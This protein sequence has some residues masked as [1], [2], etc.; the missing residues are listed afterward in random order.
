MLCMRIPMLHYAT[1]HAVA[2]NIAPSRALRLWDRGTKTSSP[3]HVCIQPSTETCGGEGSLIFLL[4]VFY[5][6]FSILDQFF[7]SNKKKSNFRFSK[8]FSFKARSSVLNL[9]SSTQPSRNFVFLD[10]FWP[11]QFDCIFYLL[12]LEYFFNQCSET[13]RVRKFFHRSCLERDQVARVE[14]SLVNRSNFS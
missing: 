4:Q 8:A 3:I 2:L 10:L 7:N 1:T 6:F 11:I 14:K 9:K 5:C 12:I 13:F